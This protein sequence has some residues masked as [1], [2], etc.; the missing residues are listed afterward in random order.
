MSADRSS[1][2]INN[3]PLA[4]SSPPI[5]TNH[6]G[7]RGRAVD[8]VCVSVCLSVQLNTQIN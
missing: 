4:L 5:F 2:T 6:F 8:P 1:F 7:G 3:K